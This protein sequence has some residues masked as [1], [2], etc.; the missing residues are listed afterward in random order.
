MRLTFEDMAKGFG[1]VLLK[2]GFDPVRAEILAGIFTESTFDGVFS[3]GINR[4]PRFIGDVKAGT[5]DPGAHPERTG[6]GGSSAFE[7]WDGN[8]GPGITNALQCTDRAIGLARD[9]GI[10]CV[11]LRNTNHWMRGGTYGVR[12]ARRGFLFIG[13]TN[14]I[15]NMP[16]WNGRIPTLGNNPFIMAVP[17]RQGPVVLDM[18]MSLFSYGKL[19]WHQRKGT[20]LDEYGG[21]D[22][23]DRL[24]KEPSEILDSGRILPTGLWK[25]SAFALVLDLAAAV[26][27]GGNTSREIGSLGTE[28]ALSQVFIAIDPEQYMS[29]EQL[30]ALIE[31]TINFNAEHNPAARYPG[32]RSAH[33]RRINRELGAEVPDTLWEKILAL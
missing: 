10:G 5:I 29:G 18:A 17:Y 3:H 19:E 11:G 23:R 30:V 6:E 33:D 24:T 9:N 16:P 32:Q 7:Q 13:W 26:L 21:Y 27:S 25:G 31:Q 28:T 22:H 8:R 2:N 12:A 4:F 14:T 1:S 20:K 15:P